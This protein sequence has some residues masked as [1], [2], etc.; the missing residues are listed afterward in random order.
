MVCLGVNKAT[1]IGSLMVAILLTACVEE[2][3]PPVDDDQVTLESY[4]SDDKR[5][6]P[7]ALVAAAAVDPAPVHQ[8]FSFDHFQKH[9]GEENS[10]IAPFDVQ[11]QLANLA[12]GATG[13]TLQSI[14]EAG[15][16]P[17]LSDS[18]AAE[19]MAGLSL[20]EQR[21]DGLASVE[22]Q[23]WLWGQSGYR[24][25]RDYLQAQA[26]LFGSE[27]AGLDFQN[28]FFSARNLIEGALDEQQVLDDA[29]ALSR[30]ILA[31]S[32]RLQIAWADDLTIERF[33]GR[34][35]EHE[36]QR[37]MSMLRIDGELLAAEGEAY[38][39]VAVPLAE[40]GLSLVV[41][42]PDAG[43]FD[44]V[45]GRMDAV[46]WSQLNADLTPV[47][48]RFNLPLF[49]LQRILTDS[50]LPSLE[51]AQDEQ[52]ADFSPVN[53]AG[54]LYLK[55]QYQSIKLGVAE[56]GLN[57]ITM[58]AAVLA[59]TQD[60][61]LY[62]FDPPLLG[63][64]FF[65]ADSPNS[66]PCFYPPDQQPFLFAVYESGTESLL[67]LGQVKSLDGVSVEADWHVSSWRACGDSPPVEVYRDKKSLQC[68]YESG[69]DY[70]EMRQILTDAGIHVLGAWEGSDGKDYIQVCGGADDAIN[71][72]VIYESQLAAA[73]ALGFA[74]R[75]SLLIE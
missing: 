1:L 32:T 18:A 42:V 47:Q 70:L 71:I 57:A 14:A 44:A 68:D 21:I 46:F 60:E 53:G 8:A 43:H 27:V 38:R 50:D 65:M 17:S 23:R 22:R 52:E 26:E 16:W 29:D 51:V 69:S 74:L 75:S 12:L 48:S 67:H 5:L 13:E 36:A 11:Q 6:S 7:D 10:F 35:G 39:A 61:P 66:N 15:G 64:F 73:E 20:W 37:Q 41:I 63:S 3:T 2:G 49:S 33:E 31:H 58:T 24:F 4:S 45:R 72:F 28:E 19:I 25:N 9:A 55:S 40:E 56:S 59:A 62:L 34:F 30:L 54:F